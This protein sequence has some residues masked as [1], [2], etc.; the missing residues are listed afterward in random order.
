MRIPIMEEQPLH[1]HVFLRFEAT[2]VYPTYCSFGVMTNDAMI[3]R[4]HPCQHSGESWLSGNRR[5]KGI[6]E[7]N[8]SSANTSISGLFFGVAIKLR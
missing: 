3:D 6:R 4:M 1:T 2:S 7:K 8:P 5:S